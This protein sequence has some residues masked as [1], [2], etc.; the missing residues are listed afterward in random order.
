MCKKKKKK[1]EKKNSNT[2]HDVKLKIELCKSYRYVER[3]V[4]MISPNKNSFSY[5]L[6]QRERYN[7]I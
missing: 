3:H 6:I 1:K 2:S 5:V 4:K 7:N